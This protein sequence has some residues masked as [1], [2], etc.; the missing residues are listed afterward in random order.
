[1]PW[2]V[3]WH[4][5]NS[6]TSGVRCCDAKCT[7]SCRALA[8]QKGHLALTRH[9][10]RKLLSLSPL[11]SCLQ[12]SIQQ[13]FGCCQG[14]FL[15]L[16]KPPSSHTSLSLW[17]CCSGF[18]WKQW[19][20]CSSYLLMASSCVSAHVHSCLLSKDVLLKIFVHRFLYSGLASNVLLGAI[21]FALVWISYLLLPLSLLCC[22]LLQPCCAYQV[23]FW[24]S[25]TP[26][27]LTIGLA[28]M[29]IAKKP[30]LSDRNIPHE[31]SLLR[32]P[33]ATTRIQSWK[34]LV[35]SDHF[36]LILLLPSGKICVKL[37]CR[38]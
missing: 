8:S 30:L 10:T 11:V 13:Q 14:C 35:T 20:G 21:Y 17:G 25:C 23:H 4:N 37:S 38:K 15:L 7:L 32:D 1:M 19:N 22:A 9:C 24:W 33:L 36:Y 26:W 31:I 18:C 2:L 29:G 27:V 12:C 28:Q 6:D 34:V 16:L 5:R 3:W